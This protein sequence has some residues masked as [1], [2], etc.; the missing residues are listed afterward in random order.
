MTSVNEKHLASDNERSLN[1]QDVL[2]R[3]G[4]KEEFKRDFSRVELFGLSFTIVGVVQSIAW[5]P[6]ET[7]AWLSFFIHQQSCTL[8][9]NPLWRSS[10]H[11]LGCKIQLFN[12]LGQCWLVLVV[13]MLC[14]PNFCRHGHGWA[15]LCCTNC[16]WPLL[17]DIQI[18]LSS[19]PKIAFM[20]GR[21]WADDLSKEIPMTD[22]DAPDVNT[23]AYIA[24]LA[25]VDWGCATQL[26]AA[27]NIGSGGS[28]K[29]TNAQ[30]LWVSHQSEFWTFDIKYLAAVSIVL[31]SSSMPSWPVLP[32]RSLLGCSGRISL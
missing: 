7:G 4:Y 1:D 29:A 10:R 3:L 30:T 31:F 20:V 9:L 5:V 24:G 19:L 13:Y 27:I 17:L 14:V 15:W 28:F 18:L 6:V 25:S 26:V 21:M 22:R 16:W 12:P 11:G 32:P 23:S 2:A 8:V